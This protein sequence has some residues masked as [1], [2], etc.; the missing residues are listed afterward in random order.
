MT[1]VLWIS[2]GVAAAVLVGVLA[3]SG[4]MAESAQTFGSTSAVHGGLRLGCAMRVGYFIFRGWMSLAS[5]KA[6]S[7]KSVLSGS[8]ENQR[9]SDPSKPA[10]IFY[11]N[12]MPKPINRMAKA[13]AIPEVKETVTLRIDQDVQ[14]FFQ[15]DGRGWQDRIN[16]A[17]R[18]AAGKCND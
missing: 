8:P 17:L 6:S 7:R 9:P 14:D 13:V 3:G 10:E 16:A 5:E 15:E 12:A 4:L 11:L 18:K 2:P 1:D